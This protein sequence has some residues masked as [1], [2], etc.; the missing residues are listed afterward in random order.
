MGK[1]VSQMLAHIAGVEVLEGAKAASGN[2][3]RITALVE[4]NKEGKHFAGTEG[5]DAVS[6]RLAFRQLQQFLGAFKSLTKIVYMA[7]QG[8]QICQIR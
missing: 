7:E 5:T 6:A 1:S 8:R 4:G 2:S 3:F